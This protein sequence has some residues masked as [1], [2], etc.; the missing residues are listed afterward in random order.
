MRLATT[1]LTAFL[2][3]LP[4]ASFC[5]EPTWTIMVYGDA[6]N[7]LSPQFVKDI[8]KME[9]VGSSPS[10]R[11]V[12]ES[13]FDAS[14]DDDNEE[15]GLPEGLSAG[16]TRFLVERTK[17]EEALGSK[18]AMRLRELNH[19]D[20]EV[21]RDFIVWAIRKYP[22]DRY[23]VIFWDH[24]GQWEG[25][26]GDGQDGTL[27]SADGILTAKIRSAM[28]DALRR[29]SAQKF[30][31]IA[32]DTCLMGGIEV[33]EDFHGMTDLF[34][35]CPEIDYGDGWNYAKAL[36]W[37][38]MNPS[39]SMR[40]F[41][42]N[43]T[44]SWGELHMTGD[45]EGDR[46]L[47]AHCAYDMAKYPQVR[48]AFKAFTMAMMKEISPANLSIPKHRRK[49]VEYSLSVADEDSAS[50]YIDLG[51]FARDFAED[52]ASPPALR[53]TGGRLAKAIDEMVI[54]K[55]MGEEKY[56]ALGLSVWYP[57]KREGDDDDGD[58]DN[59]VDKFKQYKGLNLLKDSRWGDYIQTVWKCRD[60]FDDEPVLA[61]V[62]NNKLN[63]KLS[64]GLKM[65]VTVESGKGAF[66]LNGALLDK[67]RSKGK[68]DVVYLGQV[69]RS[70]IDGPGKYALAWNLK[71]LSAVDGQG[72]KVFLCA[73][74]KDD[75]GHL[76]YSCA[77]YRKSKNSKPF[78]VILL[79]QVKA[80]DARILKMLDASDDDLAPAPIT[81]RPGSILSPLYVM[82]TR[83]GSNP[84]KWKEGL[85]PS[86]VN[87]VV[88]QDGLSA[89]KVDMSP[90]T[91]GRYSLE[92]QVED[93]NGSS[94]NVIEYELT[95]TP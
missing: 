53:E 94:S 55:V 67:G 87:L 80:G 73:F 8:M 14:N 79:I 62:K 27:D 64:A 72:S 46:A 71:A 16:T 37:L 30:D 31:F 28:A 82:E 52:P 2:L 36:D 90:L 57:I 63:A 47:A 65:S 54:S 7:N 26:G 3:A 75:S 77:Q 17:D 69:I 68:N 81:P 23:G 48:E 78:N 41:G 25:F 83:K 86:G 5:A 38:K 84:D 11:I 6:D 50:D 20:P 70:E 29:S 85:L 15:A 12:V 61:D 66:L 49:T 39:A 51:Q 45:N 4:S 76:W 74:P 18:P 88:P 40:D 42:V 58:N 19:D 24:G 22:A 1:L 32:F 56:S 21:L 60:D 59:G 93:I 95:V 44:K 92:L 9:R 35:A 34:L 33:L 89:M 13:D 43:E 10:F 91:A